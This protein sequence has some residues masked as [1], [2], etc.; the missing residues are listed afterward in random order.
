MGYGF[1]FFHFFFVCVFGFVLSI[2]QVSR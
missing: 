1:F 2:F